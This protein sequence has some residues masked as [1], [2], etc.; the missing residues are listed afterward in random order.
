MDPPRRP[1]GL[2]LI[3]ILCAFKSYSCAASIA[4]IVWTFLRDHEA[5]AQAVSGGASFIWLGLT[6]LMLVLSAL[7][8]TGLFQRTPQ[9]WSLAMFVMMYNVMDSLGLLTV[10]ALGDADAIGAINP[11][12]RTLTMLC[13]TFATRAC[14]GWVAYVYLLRRDVRE[15]LYVSRQPLLNRVLYD[16]GFCSFAWIAQAIRVIF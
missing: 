10:V 7:A 16:V 8:A 12:G 1:F 11:R 2:M 14:L 5:F 6:L 9:G 15:Y 4:R 13:V 3:A